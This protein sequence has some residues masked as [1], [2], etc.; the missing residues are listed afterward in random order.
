[1]TATTKIGELAVRRSIE[2]DA[3]PERVWKEF[4]S[5]ERMGLWYTPAGGVEYAVQ[6][7]WSSSHTSAASS[8][9]RA[10]TSGRTASKRSRLPVASWYST[11]HGS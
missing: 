7:A 10:I 9:R 4:Q 6:S 3:T 11:L 8:R 5:A 2:I 1:M